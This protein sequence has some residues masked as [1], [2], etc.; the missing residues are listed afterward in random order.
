MN[1]APLALLALASSVGGGHLA[2]LRRLA[3]LAHPP[4][5]WH[6]SFTLASGAALSPYT[7]RVQGLGFRVA[8][9]SDKAWGSELRVSGPWAFEAF[10]LLLSQ[11]MHHS[12]AEADHAKRLKFFKPPTAPVPS[13]HLVFKPLMRTH[14][15][16]P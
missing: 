1:P 10:G 15:S 14:N 9:L 8:G 6:A 7:L 5:P 13:H 12:R 4:V 2:K 16:K 3:L 11:T